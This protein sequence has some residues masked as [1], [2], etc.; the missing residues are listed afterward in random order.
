MLCRSSLTGNL[1]SL[2]F[3]LSHIYMYK[4]VSLIHSLKIHKSLQLFK[5]RHMKKSA[6]K[7]FF[8][9]VNNL[10]LMRHTLSLASPVEPNTFRPILFISLE[11]SGSLKYKNNMI[12]T[13]PKYSS[14][15]LWPW[16]CMYIR[17]YVTRHCMYV[18]DYVS[19]NT[20]SCIWCCMLLTWGK[21]DVLNSTVDKNY[22]YELKYMLC[23]LYFWPGCTCV[24]GHFSQQL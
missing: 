9:V 12:C 17:D 21:R 6:L 22:W 14:R 15:V 19:S 16:H 7:M 20:V 4:P 24:Y 5:A 3:Q 2:Y 10:Y 23:V 1:I 11:D 8:G 13:W 18:R